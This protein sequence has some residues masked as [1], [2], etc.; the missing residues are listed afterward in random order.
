MRRNLPQAELFIGRRMPRFP[1][2]EIKEHVASGNNGHLFRAYNSRT[3]SS[4]AFKVIPDENLPHD[5]TQEEYL[6]E[7][8]KPNAIT[9]QAAVRYHDVFSYVDES[10]GFRG[11]VFVCDYVDGVDLRTYMKDR[12]SDID[13]AFVKRFL[14]TML[15]LLHELELRRYVH[16][17][18]H[19]GNILVARAEYDIDEQTTFRVTDFGV[20]HFSGKARHPSDYLFLAEILRDLLGCIDYHSCDGRDRYAYNILRD[21]FLRRHLIETDSS[22]D[23]LARN[24]QSL[25]RKLDTIND[26]YSDMMRTE[27]KHNLANPFDY[28]N[29]EQIGNSHLLLK[30][31]YSDRL[32]GLSDIRARLNLVLTGP[33]GCGKTTVFRALSLEYLM[34]IQE[35]QPKAIQYIGIYYR[36]DDLYFAFPR[37]REPPGATLVDIPMHYLV[38]T[39]VSTMLEQVRNW[40]RRHFHAEFARWERVLAADLWHLFELSPPGHP[41][42][43]SLSSLIQWLKGRERRRAVGMRRATHKGQVGGLFEPS[44]VIRTCEIVRRRL[45]F[46][47]DRPIYYFIDDYSEPK[48]TADLQANLNRLLMHRSADVYFKISTESPV[49]FSREDVDGKKYVESR[50]FNLLH[51]GLRYLIDES[52]KRSEFIDDLFSRRFRE[53]E[54]YPVRN[55][56]DLLGKD[57]RNENATARDLVADSESGGERPYFAGCATIAAMCSGDI[58][59]II[60]LVS[61]MVDDYGAENLA[62]STR[63]PRIP[64]HIQNRSIRATAGEFVESIRTLPGRGPHLANIITAFGNVARSYLLHRTSKNGNA[65]TPH[66]ASR[67]EPYEELDLSANASDVLRELLRYS[68]FIEDPRG[69]SRRG[70]P[71]P[72]YYLRRYLIPHFL[73]TFGRRDSIQ[74]EGSQMEKLLLFPSNFERDMKVRAQI[75][76][77][78]DFHN[79]D[80]M[81]FLYHE[82]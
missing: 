73:L 36:C 18:L 23:S 54:S 17:D 25:V 34:S 19:A 80:Q 35:D 40:A 27:K 7:A 57:S 75:T 74:L 81:E 14:R 61:K 16:G 49:S 63:I 15:G 4:L 76:D 79:K 42:G 38:A 2:H 3:D 22:A 62:R 55:L 1:D 44:H 26:R 30:S 51:L 52:A 69:K 8:R 68:V 71:V 56:G 13:I 53:V 12:A 48:I 64:F 20:Q 24:P 59:Y 31:L 32:L 6:N 77:D 46:L 82:R 9:N 43:E 72:R 21:D 58:H 37:Y 28:P 5:D 65:I 33:R 39:L 10:I 11:I 29:C 67:I 60:R 70:K 66:Q 47:E 50:E 41:G 78:T 45:T